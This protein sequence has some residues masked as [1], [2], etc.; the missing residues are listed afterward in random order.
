MKLTIFGATGRTGQHLIEQALARGYHIT[1]FARNSQKLAVYR[2]RIEIAEGDVQ[3]ADAVARAISGADAIVSVLGPTQNTPDYQVT[4]GTHHILD[5]MK[6]H[7]VDRLVISA[8]AAVGDYRD[9]PK[10]FHKLMNLLIKLVSRHVYEDMKRVVET[11]RNSDVEWT[12]VRVPM[13][14]DDPGKGDVKTG[15]VGK[16]IGPRVTRADMA[17]FMLDQ[18]TSDTYLRQAPAIS[19]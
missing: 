13:L 9:E 6:R 1:A 14:T 2:D 17:S 4:R 7:G 16:G 5:A 8:G 3:D 15:Y 11:V 10:L 12:V 19:N 18:V